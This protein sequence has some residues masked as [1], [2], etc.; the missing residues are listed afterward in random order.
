MKIF[1]ITKYIAIAFLLFQITNLRAQIQ[2]VKTMQSGCVNDTQAFSLECDGCTIVS[3]NV[4]G[5]HTS[6]NVDDPGI[7]GFYWTAPG[8]YNVNCN[9]IYNGSSD[10][11][12]YLAVISNPVT[13]E[14]S[15]SRTPSTNPITFGQQVVFTASP[16][17]NGG[18]APTYQW[19]LNNVEQGGQ[20][21]YEYVNSAL[22]N[23]DQVFVR[24][25]SN[26]ACPAPSYDDSNPITVNVTYP[27]STTPVAQSVSIPY[28]TSTTL[29][30]SGAVSGQVYRWYDVPTG[31]GGYYEGLSY[32]TPILQ[33]HK[34][35]YVCIRNPSTSGESVRV[36]QTVTLIVPPPAIPT[37]SI[38]T[39][40]PR[41]LTR[42][43]PP[44]DVIWSWQGTNEN[45]LYPGGTQPVLTLTQ[46][47]PISGVVR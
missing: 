37:L 36:P 12:S 14:V 23:G 33:N 9:F 16:V 25:F 17:A 19:F 42:G 47:T 15:L 4:S 18:P 20:T 6:F 1:S 40:G 38:N 43:T 34:T 24:M 46:A 3:W 41:T 22:Q 5:P 28:N 13:P 21:S 29:S 45:G 31:N 27:I 35:Y 10:S 26:A 30:A 7:W 8:S 39:C 11:R 44:A 32:P 2:I